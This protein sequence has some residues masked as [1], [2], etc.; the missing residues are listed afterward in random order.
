MK[1]KLKILP[2]IAL[3]ATI[4]FGVT[5]YFLGVDFG[6]SESKR[7]ASRFAARENLRLAISELEICRKTK[8]GPTACSANGVT[9]AKFMSQTHPDSF[10]FYR[11]GVFNV[12]LFDDHLLAYAARCTVDD[13]TGDS[14]RLSAWPTNKELLTQEQKANGAVSSLYTFAQWGYVIDATCII[15]I[16]LPFRDL[17]YFEFGRVNSQ[18]GG[19]HWRT[20]DK[21]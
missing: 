4:S 17:A 16:R 19:W 15:A 21:P 1:T 12:A 11:P 18:Q 8:A 6:T 14:Y 13:Q 7:I 20:H 5:F 2:L 10:A 9:L 3:A